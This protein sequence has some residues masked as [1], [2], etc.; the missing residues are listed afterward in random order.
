M[1]KK[2]HRDIHYRYDFASDHVQYLNLHFIRHFFNSLQGR[3]LITRYC[4]IIKYRYLYILFINMYLLR[5][6]VY[7]YVVVVLK[8]VLF[9]RLCPQPLK[10]DLICVQLIACIIEK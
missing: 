5:R 7:A 4:S 10:S 2:Y 3:L 1:L 6:H 9:N 8:R